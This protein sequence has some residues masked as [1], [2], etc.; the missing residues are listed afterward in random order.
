MPITM[1]Q[2]LYAHS[3]PV[4]FTDPTGYFSIGELLKSKTFRAGTVN[5]AISGLSTV[6]SELIIHGHLRNIQITMLLLDMSL[7]FIGGV[8]SAHVATIAAEPMRRALNALI[9]FS[10]SIF[11][12]LGHALMFGD[13]RDVNI[14]K[15]ALDAAF[16][17]IVSTLFGGKHSP[18]RSA[19]TE[20]IWRHAAYIRDV[21][22]ELLMEISSFFDKLTVYVAGT[23]F[24]NWFYNL[25]H[26]SR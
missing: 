9:G 8:A 1:N 22:N 5:M 3:N 24:K 20:C 4:M 12:E 23:P 18:E 17:A 26:G 14:S 7:A 25:V 6:L 10:Q 2:Y 15:M 19:P 21:R 16:S 11:T 13:I